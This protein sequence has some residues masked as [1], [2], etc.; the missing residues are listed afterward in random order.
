M[1][2]S[3]RLK[4]SALTFGA[5]DAKGI[6]IDRIPIEDEIIEFCKAPFCNGFGKSINCPPHVMK[7]AKAK[8]WIRSFG[9]ALVFKIDVYPDLLLSKQRFDEFKKIYVMATKLEELATDQGL[10]AFGLAAGSCKSVFCRKKPCQALE[11]SSECSNPRFA[12]PSME[13]IGINV[14]KLV[15]EIGWPIHMILET[16]DPRDIP[17]AL[18]AGL[19]LY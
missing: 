14:F 3:S 1:S 17:S 12:R 9:N 18:L 5:D 2:C 11:D 19:L 6:P 15:R 8:K 4:E 7:P 10:T 16:S 13:A